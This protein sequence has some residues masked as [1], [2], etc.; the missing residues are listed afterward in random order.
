MRIKNG[1]VTYLYPVFEAKLVSETGFC[2]SL[3]TD[4]IAIGWIIND[5]DKAYDK[6]DC[7]LKAFKRLAQKLK[8]AFSRLPICILA[9]ALYANDP[10]MSI[11]KEWNGNTSSH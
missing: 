3:A 6:Q 4:P 8:K 11:C 7:E 9:D 10:V 2:I 1:K 5:N